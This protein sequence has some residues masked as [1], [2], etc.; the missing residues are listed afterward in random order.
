MGK[1]SSR[2]RSPQAEKTDVQKWRSIWKQGILGAWRAGRS[3]YQA[4][5]VRLDAPGED[6]AHCT[7][8]PYARTLDITFCREPGVRREV[9]TP[10]SQIV[11][12][13]HF[14]KKRLREEKR[15]GV[16]LER[17]LLLGCRGGSVS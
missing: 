11:A 3:G 17:R 10:D 4:P 1:K 12:C 14:R 6:E 9:F 15:K 13:V 16:L 8:L 2:E 7:P 5:C